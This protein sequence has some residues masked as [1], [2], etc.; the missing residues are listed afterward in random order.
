MNVAIIGAVI[1]GLYAV[2]FLKDRHQVTLF[3]KK[4]IMPIYVRP[5]M[6]LCKRL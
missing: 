2:Y 4:F 1:S 3:E 5:T 6:G